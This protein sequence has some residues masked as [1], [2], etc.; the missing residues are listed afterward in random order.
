VSFRKMIPMPSPTGRN[1]AGLFLPADRFKSLVRRV[2]AAYDAAM[3]APP[4]KARDDDRPAVSEEV[5][6]KIY[7]FL[8]DRLEPEDADEVLKMLGL[9]GRP[10]SAMDS[11]KRMA[12]DAAVRG[13]L[14]RQ[15]NRNSKAFFE[16]F[17]NAA[18][19]GVNR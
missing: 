15:P 2:E 14:S 13:A 7:A 1:S 4:A 5:A 10:A 19:I 17:A 6:E 18:R 9:S 16:R 12:G 8:L 11:R 3:P